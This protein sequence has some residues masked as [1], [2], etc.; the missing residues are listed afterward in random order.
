MF[1]NNII[2]MPNMPASGYHDTGAIKISPQICQP[3]RAAEALEDSKVD[4]ILSESA[5]S[6]VTQCFQCIT[7]SLIEEMTDSI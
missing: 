1:D 4:R 2:L 7:L 5:R 3:T 6:N